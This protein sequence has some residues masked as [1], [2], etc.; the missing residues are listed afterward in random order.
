MKWSA[1]S[2]RM[3]YVLYGPVFV[4]VEI[5]AAGFLRKYSHAA[6]NMQGRIGHHR[7]MDQESS[8]C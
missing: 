8:L 5:A 4:P 6:V 2:F 3:S 7:E 1:K